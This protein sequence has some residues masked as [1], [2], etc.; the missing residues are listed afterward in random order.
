MTYRLIHH[1][2]RR[3]IAEFP[4]NLFSNGWGALHSAQRQ[5]RRHADGG[6][7]VI[8]TGGEEPILYLPPDYPE[9]ALG[10]TAPAVCEVRHYDAPGR[11]RRRPAS[12]AAQ[13]TLP[14]E[15]DRAA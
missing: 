9:S 3:L 8:L 14:I 11:R 12:S 13:E 6:T 4:E 1:P 5:A 10:D 15:M 2:S 7:P